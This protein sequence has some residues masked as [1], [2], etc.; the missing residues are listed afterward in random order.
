VPKPLGAGLSAK[1]YGGRMSRGPAHRGGS[2]GRPKAPQ[3]LPHADAA[4]RPTLRTIAALAGVHVST[5]SR[6]LAPGGRPATRTASEE[7]AQRVRAVALEVGYAPNPLATG[8]RTRRTGLVGVV[9]PRLTDVVLATIYEGIDAAAG[10]QQMQTFVAN[11]QDDP[12]L[13]RTKVEIL[14][15]RRVDGLILG[16]SPLDGRFADELAR[17]KVPFVMVNRRAGDHPSVTCDDYAGGRMVAEHLLRLGHERPAVVAGEPYASTGV[18]RTAGFVDRYAEAGLSIPSEWVVPSSFDVAGG[19]LAAGKL[20]GERSGPSA[21]FAVND[22]TAIGVIGAMR[23]HGLTP[24]A[25]VAVIGFNDVSVAA[26]LP[27]PLTTVSSPMHEI[28]RRATHQLLERLAGREARSERLA[29]T[30]VVRE[31]CGGAPPPG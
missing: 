15:D 16:D 23:E 8:L 26:D 24:G 5:V 14:L 13:R 17:R 22:F 28:G 20:F 30:L 7:T 27:I 3:A 18:D 21:V 10:E 29:P 1:S 25:D 2:Q 9:V 11:S 4:G 19:R 12:A 31:S 6:V